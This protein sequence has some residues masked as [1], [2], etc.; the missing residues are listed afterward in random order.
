MGLPDIDALA[1][2]GGAKTNYQGVGVVNPDTDRDAG[3]ANQAYASVAAM[4]QTSPRVWVQFT[5][6]ATTGALVLVAWAAHWKPATPTPPVLARSAA[7]KFTIT[8]PASITDELSV[9]HTVAFRGGFGNAAST[10]TVL[11]PVQVTATAGNVLEACISAS[12]AFA[13]SVGTTVDVFGI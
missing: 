11:G 7:G 10:T 9:N 13:D 12:G 1:T 4:T 8:F 2:Y 6:A 5:T 3:D